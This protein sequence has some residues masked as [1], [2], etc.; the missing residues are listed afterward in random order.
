MTA[1]AEPGGNARRGRRI[2]IALCLAIT[3]SGAVLRGW[4][5]GRPMEEGWHSLGLH[6]AIPARNHLQN[7]L[8]TTWGFMVQNPGPES[9][10]HF[11]FYTRHPPLL[12]IPAIGRQYSGIALTIQTHSWSIPALQTRRGLRHAKLPRGR[13]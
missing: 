12:R 6:F 13:S 5:L 4:N 8:G 3:V 1:M 7:G 10:E 2:F 9:P 11:E